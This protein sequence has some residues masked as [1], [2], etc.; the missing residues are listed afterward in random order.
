MVPRASGPA[1]PDSR[2][3]PERFVDEISP[4]FMPGQPIKFDG[5]IGKFVTPGNDTPLD[6]TIRYAAL[7][8]ETWTGYIKFN[9]EGE[10]PTR[11]GGLL[12]DNYVMPPREDLGDLDPTEWPLGLN[13]KPA[14]PWLR[15][16]L[17]PIQNI[18]T[19]EIFTFQTTSTTGK[20]A[21][22]ALLRNYNRMRRGNPNEVPII[23]LKPSS[24]MH[25]TFGKVN[26]PSFVIC[27]RTSLDSAQLTTLADGLNDEIPESLG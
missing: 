11:V 2:T 20:T 10:Q 16:I 25:R 8:P 9:G 1:V 26:V 13:G 7:L 14:D 19:S 24:Y 5:K 23:Q 15:Q 22:G 18:A 27:G 12:Y 21:V 6:E 3:A 17:I 4:S